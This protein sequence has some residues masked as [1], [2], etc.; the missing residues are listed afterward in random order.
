MNAVQTV[1]ASTQSG[2]VKV[3]AEGLVIQ[4]DIVSKIVTISATGIPGIILAVGIAVLTAVIGV[5]ISYAAYKL[6]M[7]FLK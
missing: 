4:F 5:G 6:T 2:A 7:K 1:G 3:L